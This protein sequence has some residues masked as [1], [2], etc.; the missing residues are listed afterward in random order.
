MDAP[1]FRRNGLCLAEIRS[2]KHCSVPGAPGSR[3]V[4]WAF[5]VTLFVQVVL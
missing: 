4:S 5:C 2:S 1:L 3:R